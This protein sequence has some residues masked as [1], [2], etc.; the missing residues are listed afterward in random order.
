MIFLN[1]SFQREW[2]QNTQVEL[3]ICSLY[4]IPINL[5]WTKT[6]WTETWN[7][8]TTTG[9]WFTWTRSSHT[10]ITQT[11]LTLILSFCV[12]LLWLVAATGRC[13]GKDK[14]PYVWVPEE[15]TAVKPAATVCLDP[16]L[17]PGVWAALTK[18]VSLPGTTTE[19]HP[20]AAPP[21]GTEQQC[22]LTYL[23][24]SCLSTMSPR[25]LWSTCTPSTPRSLSQFI[26]GLP[27]WPLAPQCLCVPIEES[28]LSD[29]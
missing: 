8:L 7:C 4:Q 29:L 23:I 6:H 14:Y 21:P 17:T 2:Y 16:T 26:L 20:S 22:M 1:F 24:T 11:G 13:S 25:T 3:F 27:S 15:C 19:K 9:G 5:N 12:K 28:D 10:L 18:V